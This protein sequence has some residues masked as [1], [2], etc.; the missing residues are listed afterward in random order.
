MYGLT[1]LHY[2]V[3]KGD[4]QMT[5]ALLEKG[6]D[7]F[8]QDNQGMMPIR[9]A[10]LNGRKDLVEALLET[11]E[12]HAEVSLYKPLTGELSACALEP[13]P[14]AKLIPDDLVRRIVSWE[15]KNLPDSADFLIHLW[16]DADRSVALTR[17]M[18]LGLENEVGAV[19][20]ED[21]QGSTPLDRALKSSSVCVAQVLW[22]DKGCRPSKAFLT[23]T[24]TESSFL[25]DFTK[26]L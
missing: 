15:S 13:A 16:A 21:E 19:S 1:A 3:H 25:N 2:V 5:Q 14:D 24:D 10:I 12:S 20:R 7:P 17:A 23:K 11:M 22:E 8:A 6:A 4:L 9:R 18:S 26:P